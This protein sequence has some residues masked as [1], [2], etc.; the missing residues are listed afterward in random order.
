M[1]L[2]AGADDQGFGPPADNVNGWAR[3]GFFSTGISSGPSSAGG[4]NCKAW[5]SNLGTDFGVVVRLANDWMVPLVGASVYNP[6][7]PWEANTFSCDVAP[8]VWCV[9]DDP[10]Q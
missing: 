9:E 5:S 3:G 2:G 6:I 10:D 7:A 1:T 4:S 8:H